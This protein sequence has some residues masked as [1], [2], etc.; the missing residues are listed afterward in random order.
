[1][2]VPAIHLLLLPS[3]AWALR[4][5]TGKQRQQ[6]MGGLGDDSAIAA[7]PPQAEFD[8]TCADV[9]DGWTACPHLVQ[10]NME[11]IVNLTSWED[12]EAQLWLNDTKVLACDPSVT[13]KAEGSLWRLN[14]LLRTGMSYA[15]PQITAYLKAQQDGLVDLVT[16]MLENITAPDGLKE[17]VVKT[18]NETQTGITAVFAS[19]RV[20]QRA[21]S[22]RSPNI[23]NT[24][25]AQIKMPDGV[26]YTIDNWQNTPV[27]RVHHAGSGCQ[28]VWSVECQ[29]QAL[30]RTTYCPFEK[31]TVESRCLANGFDPSCLLPFRGIS[32][33]TNGT[34][35]VRKPMSD[36]WSEAGPGR[37][38]VRVVKPSSS[39]DIDG[40]APFGGSIGPEGFPSHILT[41][42]IPQF[43]TT[44]AK[45]ICEDLPELLRP[46]CEFPLVQALRL[47]GWTGP[48][49]RMATA[50][51]A[52]IIG[53][54]A[55][56]KSYSD[57]ASESVVAQIGEY[58]PGFTAR[59]ASV[60]LSAEGSLIS[61]SIRLIMNGT[62]YA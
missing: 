12:W 42:T 23:C 56:L 25:R 43:T 18:V 33:P 11:G 45:N 41:L 46:A 3:A 54:P 5:D 37:I 32:S 62:V 2:L 59:E 19:P 16:Q 31:T 13:G 44:L 10:A 61:M 30:V 17:A 29:S 27:A 52:M 22:T 58:I 35:F 20:L 21:P 53:Y 6:R 38:E 4:R 39:A 49:F 57:G 8:T 36:S 34:M 15:G 47:V 7:T 40:G 51:S 48:N 14:I 9:E 28:E 1:M 55:D 26:S 60:S 24:R 50:D